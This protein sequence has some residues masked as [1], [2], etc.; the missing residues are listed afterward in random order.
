MLGLVSELQR[1]FRIVIAGP[2]ALSAL[3][4]SLRMGFHTLAIQKRTGDI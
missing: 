3:L 2:T 1:K 4:N